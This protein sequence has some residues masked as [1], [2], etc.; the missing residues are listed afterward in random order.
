MY[1]HVT[2]PTTEEIGIDLDRVVTNSK[3]K[4]LYSESDSESSIEKDDDSS[5][6]E[7]ITLIT[8]S[9][10]PGFVRVFIPLKWTASS[11]DPV[12]NVTATY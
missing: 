2:D 1:I 6:D 8:Q 7:W 3:E 4:E 9:H 11:M 10:L 12:E 5:G